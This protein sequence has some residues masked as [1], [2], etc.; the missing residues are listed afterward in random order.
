MSIENAKQLVR[1]LQSDKSLAMLV[2]SQPKAQ[3]EEAWRG[4]GFD[5]SE[6]DVAAF[7]ASMTQHECSETNMPKSWQCKGPCHTKCAAQPLSVS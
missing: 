2:L 4:F 1:A 5:C 3:R 7:H 6:S